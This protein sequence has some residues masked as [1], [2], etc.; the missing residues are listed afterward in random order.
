MIKLILNS[1]ISIAKS[2][3]Q[4]MPFTSEFGIIKYLCEQGTIFGISWLDT[5]LFRLA[6]ISTLVVMG[7][8]LIKTSLPNKV[9]FAVN[10]I[11]YITILSFL[12][13]KI[14]WFVI[15]GIVILLLLLFVGLKIY[16]AI[17]GAICHYRSKKEASLKD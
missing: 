8:I 10:I 4:I 3:A 15:A 1:L 12:A 9:K 2:I 7:V 6:D 14:F 11:I 5:A 17:Y 16:G 13:S